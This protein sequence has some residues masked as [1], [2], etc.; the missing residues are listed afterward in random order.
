M[1]FINSYNA[2][3]N[4]R[5]YFKV[6]FDSPEISDDNLRKF[7]EI[8]LQRLA[9]GNSGGMYSTLITATSAA[10]QAYFGAIVDEATQSSIQKSMTIHRDEALD[11]FMEAVRR[12][13]GRIRAEYDKASAVYAE[14]YPQGLEEYNQATLANLETLMLRYAKAAERHIATLGEP[15]VTSFKDFHTTFAAARAA[16]LL[17][18]GE[19]KAEKTETRGTRAAVEDQLMENLFTLAIKFMR[20]RCRHGLFRSILPP[21]RRG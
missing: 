17:A 13:E 11:A 1:F 8:H 15:F 19:V 6:I 7:A 10:Y 5:T 4:L 2:M 3:R 12:Q 14:F 21:P 16:Q 20:S 9:A 18:M